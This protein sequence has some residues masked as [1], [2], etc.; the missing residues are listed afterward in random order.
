MHCANLIKGSA[1]QD[2]PVAIPYR[3]SVMDW[4]QV[5]YVWA[6][7]FNGKICYKFRFEKIELEKK[8]WWAPKGSPL[9][10][11]TRT[12]GAHAPFKQCRRCRSIFK[13]IYREG[14]MCLDE[15]CVAFFTLPNGLTP[16]NPSY[17][18]L[19]LNERSQ[20]PRSI[21]LSSLKPEPLIIDQGNA[22][23]NYSRVSWK[24]MVCPQCGR[25]NSR[26]HWARWEC[27]SESCA[28][29]HDIQ[30]TP[31]SHKLVLP[32]HGF[33]GTGH[34]IPQ[35]KSYHP[36]ILREPTFLGNW[37]IHTFEVMA[38]TQSSAVVSHFH[39][40]TLIN[41]TFGGANDMFRAMQEANLGLQRFPMKSTRGKL[42]LRTSLISANIRPVRGEML[43]K[44]FTSNYVGCSMV[45]IGTSTN[46]LAQG[47]PYKFVV[48]VDSKPFKGAPQVIMNGLNRLIWAGK[49]TVGDMTFLQFNEL[50]ALGYFEEQSIGVRF[51]EKP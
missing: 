10:S 39:A 15:K 46:I 21:K 3:Y 37:R 14:W 26:V 45:I 34:A 11:P 6:E 42:A 48:S 7:K 8:S 40:N 30:L 47:M 29:S 4:F 24:G 35:D 51:L 44:H 16:A 23:F 2:C 17:S 5:T 50:L 20:W 12:F 18:V 28:Y 19:F 25:C 32:S 33:Q 49:H 31:L 9:P 22:S 36:I 27:H 43:T 38:G 13:K 1:N 41:Q